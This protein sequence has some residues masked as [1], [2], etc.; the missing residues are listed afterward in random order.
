METPARSLQ[1]LPALFTSHLMLPLLPSFDFSLDHYQLV[2]RSLAIFGTCSFLS[3]A[4]VPVFPGVYLQRDSVGGAGN[5]LGPGWMP[6]QG[7]ECLPGQSCECLPGQGIAGVQVQLWLRSVIFIFALSSTLH[8]GPWDQ[9]SGGSG[10]LLLPWANA[11][12]QGH[13]SGS[14]DTSACSCWLWEPQAQSCRDPCHRG[15][16][17]GG[18]AQLLAV[19]STLEGSVSCTQQLWGPRGDMDFSGSAVLWLG[20]QNMFGISALLVW[21]QLE[22]KPD[23]EGTFPDAPIS[24]LAVGA[25]CSSCSSLH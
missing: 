23:P 14:S 5:V 25:T 7:R 6:R 22:P 4:H 9:S 24:F 12:G 21:S 17:R 1:A 16:L 13:C 19:L 15:R 11:G 8:K 2:L 18:C 10:V 3:C 20:K